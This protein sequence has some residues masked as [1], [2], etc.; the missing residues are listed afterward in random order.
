M[1][2]VLSLNISS[3]WQTSVLHNHRDKQAKTTR[4]KWWKLK[5]ETSEIFKKRVIKEG[6]WKEDVANMWEKCQLA[7]ERWPQRWGQPKGYLVVEQVQRT[8][9]RKNATDVCTMTGVWTT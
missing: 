1:R 5:G 3:W 6:N 4:T 9:S 7:F 8:R 2:S